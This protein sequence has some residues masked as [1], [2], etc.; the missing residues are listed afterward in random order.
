MNIQLML[1]QLRF[2]MHGPLSV[3]FS[4]PNMLHDLW[5]VEPVDMELQVQGSDEE[6]YVNFRLR[7]SQWL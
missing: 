5:S 6:L 1:E 7:E 4:P 3:C 2:E